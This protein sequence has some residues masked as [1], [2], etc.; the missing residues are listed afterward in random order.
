M[1]RLARPWSFL[2]FLAL[3]GLVTLARSALADCS[4]NGD[5]VNVSDV[6][7]QL[8]VTLTGQS[9]NGAVVRLQLNIRSAAPRNLVLRATTTDGNKTLG[10]ARLHSI[11]YS[12][13]SPVTVG[14]SLRPNDDAT[15][16]FLGGVDTQLT[17]T[18]TAWL[19]TDNLE[20]ETDEATKVQ[21]TIT[22]TRPA[23]VSR[24]PISISKSSSSSNLRARAPASPC[25]DGGAGGCVDTTRLASLSSSGGTF[26]VQIYAWAPTAKDLFVEIHDTAT[27]ALLSNYGWISV[28]A[29]TTSSFGLY[30]V[31]LT[32]PALTAGPYNYYL[33]MSDPGAG[34]AARSYSQNAALSIVSLTSP[35]S[36]GQINCID[37]SSLL[38]TVS[39][40]VG[41]F[42]VNVGAWSSK[43]K[44]L[45]VEVHQTSDGALLSNYGFIALPAATV[46]SFSTYPVQLTVPALTP[47]VAYNYYIWMSDPNAGWGANTYSINVPI[48]VTQSSNA[49]TT[50]KAATTTAAAKTSTKI[51]TK[52]TT[53][54]AAPKISTTTATPK[55]TTTTA[56]VRTCDT[57][58]AA[59]KANTLTAQDVADWAAWSCST[60]YPSGI[61]PCTGNAA[62]CITGFPATV[63][64]TKSVTFTVSVF[65]IAREDLVF[66][67]QQAGVAASPESRLAVVSTSGALVQLT[68]TLTYSTTLTNSPYTLVWYF[69][70]T[71]EGFSAA[72]MQGQA[73]VTLAAIT[74]PCTGTSTGGC[75]DT[76][77]L[78]LS[79]SYSVGTINLNIGAW[80]A[81]K[82]DLFV[83]LQKSAS[84][85]TV[86][87]YGYASVAASLSSDYTS[88]LVTLN[89]PPL[90][91][92]P[93]QIFVWMTDPGKGW[94]S[95]SYQYVSSVTITGIVTPLPGG[96]SP[97][98]SY[99]DSCK[100]PGQYALT[101]DDGPYMYTEA[102]KTILAKYN[103]KATFF[104]N[105]FNWAPITD[106]N[107]TLQDS[108][109]K[110]HQLGMHGW[111]G[112]FV[113]RLFVQ[114]DGV[115]VFCVLL[116]IRSHCDFLN[117]ANC[118]Y[119][120]EVD[121][122]ASTIHDIIGVYPTYFR[123]PYGDYDDQGQVYV[124]SEGYR[125]VGWSIDTLDY[126]AD[127]I[128][129]TT[130]S[131]QNIKNVLE[132]Q[133][134]STT[135]SLSHDV[136]A[137]TAATSNAYLESAV[138]YI[139]SKGYTF[140]TVAECD[141]DPSGGYRT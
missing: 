36:G 129:N 113:V 77:T 51:T 99:I 61:T 120:A 125:I 98:G 14:V 139:L 76:T 108:I 20:F 37:T 117:H 26:T 54:T 35:C 130:L 45:F 15:G 110:G 90:T 89:V 2:A 138:Q 28:P 11:Q 12:D 60:W 106:Y 56:I 33:W 4:G 72:T 74:S 128:A 19:A 7:D 75:I 32:V 93:Y 134:S 73:S 79:V 135:I 68:F 112:D 24:E 55:V 101:F 115:L 57:I 46:S 38:T 70:P 17:L 141:G 5:C 91:S 124:A 82:K 109:A 40:N 107:A 126:T 25:S 84:A 31:S 83:Q 105:G 49:V 132:G 18:I 104:M 80:S 137:T 87:N 133:S 43:A 136:H 66:Q 114:A 88:Y 52:I 97:A 34:W 16:R 1:A 121:R 41:T 44:D 118:S 119:P 59:S 8:P 131:L 21:K 63:P 48:T 22:V 81:T 30:T 123:F 64:Q 3:L 127:N 102:V 71:G 65:S 13:I 140:V 67:I 50:T 103:I 6:P 47:G 116:G 86:S 9:R 95:V 58:F 29:A 96:G 27:Q 62:R 92:G 111:Y 94:P 10:E 100:T 69:A 85:V 78:P 42:T 53:T 39:A 122:L 23:P